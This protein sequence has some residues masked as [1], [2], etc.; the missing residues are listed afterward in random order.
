MKTVQQ[1]TY[2]ILRKNKI[3]KVFGNPGSNELPFLKNFPADFQYILGLHEGTVVG[4]AD[5]YAQATGQ[6]AFVN[7]HSAAGT[8][9]AMGALSNAWNSHTPLVITSGQQTRAMMGVEALLTNLEATQLPK[10]LVKWSHEPASANE[11]PHAISRAIDLAK[12]EAAGPVYV[13]IPYSDWDI[14]ID[15]QSEHLLRKNVVS[16]QCLSDH[17]LQIIAQ[18]INSAKKVAVV[19]GTDVDRQYANENALQ[20]VESLNVPVWIAPSSPRCPFPTMHPY[21]QGILPASIAGI[22][23]IFKDYDLVLVFGAPVFRYHQYEPGQYLGEN[24]ELIAFSCDIHEAARA[25]MGI[26]YIC[27]LKDSLARLSQVVEKKQDE[28]TPRPRAKL[29]EPSQGNYIKPERL[30]DLLNDLVP[31]DTIFTNESTS[32]MSILWERL[33][34]KGQGSYFFA[35]AGGLGFGMP[36]AVGIQLSHTQRRV[37][38]IIGDGSANYSITALWTA[39]QYKI[40]VIFIVLKNGTYGALRWFADVLNAENVPGM[41]VP[42]ID[43]TQIAQG[44]GVEAHRI[45]N[46]EEFINRFKQALAS[47]QPTLLEIVTVEN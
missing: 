31:E 39:A 9:N 2:D 33:N 28:V 29:A 20:F 41:D 15:E 36:A 1:Y 45:S 3:N 12:A 16:S 46:D 5:G 21:F 11:V 32:T 47:D 19:L 37:V 23:A 40:P 18:K 34:I 43:F 30:F 13:S 35:A 26:S 8:G 7:L 27:D 4:I 42:D 14:E 17:D 44:Y 24:T 10:P 6:P 25:A 38:A 22:S